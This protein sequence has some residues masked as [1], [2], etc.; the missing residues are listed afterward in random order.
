MSKNAVIIYLLFIVSTSTAFA[1]G[2]QLVLDKSGEFKINKWTIYTCEDCKYDKAEENSN[3]SKL[4]S[5]TDALRKNPVLHDIKGFDCNVMLYSEFY[6]EKKFKYGMPG[7]MSVQ[8]CYFYNYKGKVS[9]ATIEP[10]SFGIHLNQLWNPSCNSLGFINP[11][12]ITDASNPVYD[13]KKWDTAAKKTRELFFTPG[14]K[15]TISPGIDV[16]ADE[17]VFVYNPE[18]PDYWLPVT[19]K[20]IFE[21]WI[22]F[23][24]YHPDKFTSELS[25]K[26]LEDE[27]ALFSET[28]R[29]QYAYLGGRGSA[30]LLNVDVAVNDVR[31]LKPNPLYWNTNLSKA[32]L[33]IF[34]FNVLQD[35]ERYK[36]EAVQ[37]LKNNSGSY[38]LTR[39]LE[40]LDIKSLFQVIDK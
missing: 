14:K 6:G 40:A 21:A 3:Y 23:Y 9:S 24:K 33:Q 8:F 4:V 26:V 12:N 1:Q 22:E 34:S 13:K 38:F 35:K 5:L 15:V 17:T 32:D 25:L 18:R 27:Y 7:K 20:E 10:P 19:I 2:T 31:V 37:Q 36:R 28:E 30:P 29:N 11:D 16:Y 39:F